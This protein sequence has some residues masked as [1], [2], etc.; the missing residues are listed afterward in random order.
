VDRGDSGGGAVGGAVA[1]APA[2]MTRGVEVGDGT[3]L[4]TG[5][6]VW[7]GNV[8]VNGVPLC[9]GRSSAD[10]GR[11]VALG[12]MV[13][14]DTRVGRAVDVARRVGVPRVGDGWGVGVGRLRE[15]APKARR[16]I[17]AQIN[18]FMSFPLVP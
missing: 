3:T 11:R 18:R 4:G 1:V 7:V 6:A 2:S 14:R 17:K 8:P 12:T 13:I 10:A 5:V 9:T 16:T 15:Q